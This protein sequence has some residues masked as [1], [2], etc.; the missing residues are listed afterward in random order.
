MTRIAICLLA[1]LLALSVCANAAP[2]ERKDGN[3][4]F[5]TSLIIHT[6]KQVGDNNMNYWSNS[7]P[8][9]YMYSAYEIVKKV[10]AAREARGVSDRVDVTRYPIGV[11]MESPVDDGFDYNIDFAGM[12]PED[13]EVVLAAFPLT[14]A[15]SDSRLSLKPVNQGYYYGNSTDGETAVMS[16]P[17]GSLS[18]SIQQ[19]GAEMEQLAA[20]QVKAVFGETASYDFSWS[21]YKPVNGPRNLSVNLTVYLDPSQVPVYPAD[22]HGE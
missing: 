20:D 9:E 1:A 19:S 2:P 12:S 13:V 21:V 8:L 7:L 16:I 17:G 22:Y 4:I 15:F 3:Y 11:G 5:G 6:S 10:N 18:F 14:G